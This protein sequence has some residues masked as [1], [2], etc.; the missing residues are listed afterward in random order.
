MPI[1]QDETK[2]ENYNKPLRKGDLYVK[3]DIV[4]PTSLNE[5]QKKGVKAHLSNIH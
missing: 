1:P 5:T 2:A 4:F 3:F